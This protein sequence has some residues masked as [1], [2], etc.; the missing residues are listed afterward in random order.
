MQQPN[1]QSN[2]LRRLEDILDEA[3]AYENKA[4]QTGVVLLKVMKL[5]VEPQNIKRGASHVGDE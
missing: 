2:A 4:E 3:V 1:P 5:D